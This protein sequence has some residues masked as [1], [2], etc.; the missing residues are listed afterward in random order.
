MI[1]YHYCII[2]IKFWTENSGVM[3]NLDTLKYFLGYRLT[4]ISVSSFSR[5]SGQYSTFK[6]AKAHSYQQLPTRNYSYHLI[7][8]NLTPEVQTDQ[9]NNTEF[10]NHNDAV[11]LTQVAYLKL[12]LL[13]FCI[14]EVISLTFT[15]GVQITI[16]DINIA[17]LKF[18]WVITII[19][20]K[21]MYS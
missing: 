7:W 15:N 1:M 20:N 16:P 10:Y 6:Q 18:T 11:K 21:K 19:I 3:V 2:L 12:F 4:W 14:S 5:I 8:S 17:T 9:F 13:F